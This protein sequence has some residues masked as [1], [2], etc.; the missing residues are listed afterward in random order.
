MSNWRQLTQCWHQRTSCR[1]TSS[2]PDLLR[3][4]GVRVLQIMLPQ[5]IFPLIVAVWRT[6]DDVGVLWIRD[7]VILVVGLEVRGYLV[8]EFDQDHRTV[9]PVVEDGALVR[10]AHPRGPRPGG[11]TQQ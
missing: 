6:D 8:V 4:G 2:R 10:L 9:N 5:Q 7:V 11:V 3:R 1:A